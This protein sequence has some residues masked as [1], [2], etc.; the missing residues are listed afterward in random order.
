[1][2][3]DAENKVVGSLSDGDIR[4]GLSNGIGLDAPLAR[5]MKVDFKHIL[6]GDDEWEYVQSLDKDEI[7]LLPVLDEQ[8]RLH[9]LVD[10]RGYR[11][12]LPLTAFIQAGG[13]GSRLAPL[14]DDLP[15]PLLPVGDRPIL[16]HLLAHLHTQGVNQVAISGRYK[17]D[18]IREYLD[19]EE[20][21]EIEFYLEKE[22]KG[23]AG[24]LALK[25]DWS[26][27]HILM[28][29]SD[30]LTDVDLQEMYRRFAQ[31]GFDMMAASPLTRSSLDSSTA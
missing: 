15:K 25:K 20:L 9:R 2:A 24:A 22:V 18:M 8:G 28:M 29:N 1:L 19:T 10:L 4:R 26:T 3:I 31:G 21:Q 13:R 17:A 23:T 5:V 7:K 16:G 30:L 27:E 11:S 12:E 6:E 14:T